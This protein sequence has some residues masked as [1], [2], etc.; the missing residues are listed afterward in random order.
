M[1]P[2]KSQRACRYTEWGG[3]RPLRHGPEDIRSRKLFP[4][5]ALPHPKHA[6]GGQVFPQMQLSMFTRL[7]RF[8][9]DFDL[10][11]AFLPEFPTAIFLAAPNWATYRAQAVQLKRPSKP[12]SVRTPEAVS[13]E[14]CC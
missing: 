10:P 4:Y 3:Y 7:E 8:D 12:L 13:S 6:T 5:L 1:P 11:E 14:S 9:V 2:A